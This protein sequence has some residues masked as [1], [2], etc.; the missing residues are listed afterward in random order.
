M[1]QHM[2]DDAACAIAAGRR[3]VVLVVGG[4]ASHAQRRARKV[5][6]ELPWLVE[7]PRADRP[8]PDTTFGGDQPFFAPHELDRGLIRAASVF[9]LIE[10]GLRYARGETLD[11]HRR[12]IAEQWARLSEIAETNPHAW[13]RERRAPATIRTPSPSNRMVVFPYTKLMCSNPYVDQAA[14][15][16]VS[17]VEVA[18]RWGVHRDR[19]IYPHAATEIQTTPFVSRRRDFHSAPDLGL[20]G[21]RV[22]ELAGI[23]AG[24]LH[25]VDLYS[26]FPAALELGRAELGLG[27]ERDVSLTGGL[28][29]AGGPFNSYVL[30]STATMMD[31]LRAA[32]GTRGLVS[33]IGGFVNKHAFAIYSTEPPAE[34]FAH[35]DLGP[36]IAD[37]E[38]VAYREEA[39]GT[40]DGRELRAPLRRRG[41]RDGDRGLPSARRRPDVGGDGGLG[42][43][44]GDGD[45]GAVRAGGPGRA[46]GCA[47]GVTGR[48]RGEL[49]PAT[50]DPLETP[51]RVARARGSMDGKPLRIHRRELELEAVSVPA[52][53]PRG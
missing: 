52:A 5:G 3:E 19:W 23:Q 10:N 18:R 37:L 40:G 44:A 49:R 34:G 53:R 50:V 51:A 20:A 15:V 31:R 28:G 22:L 30:H 6:V 17:S 36:A 45:R 24:D 8:G 35:A 32:P 29:F 9:A 21:R 47:G 39:T 2:I 7:D 33:S 16:I 12:R 4:E 26:C 41:A 11:E 43:P 42:G 48:R 46:R 27:S 14:A 1:V 38:V 25:H 13:T